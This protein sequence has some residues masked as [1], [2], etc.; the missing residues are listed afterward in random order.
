MMKQNSFIPDHSLEALEEAYQAALLNLAFQQIEQE[1][2]AMMR[3]RIHDT[4]RSPQKIQFEKKLENKIRKERAKSFLLYKLPRIAQVAACLIAVLS[5]GAGV[6]LAASREVRSWAAGVLTGTVI[7]ESGF[8]FGNEPLTLSITDGVNMDEQL[9]LVEDGETLI[10]HESM[11]AEPARYEW[12]DRGARRLSKLVAYSD[13]IYVLFEDGYKHEAAPEEEGTFTRVWL[14]ESFDRVGL[15]RVQFDADGT[16]TV[17]ALA[18][19]DGK[20]L[21]GPGVKGCAVSTAAAG[22]G[23]LYFVTVYDEP[24]TEGISFGNRR[25]RLLAYDL[26]S[27]ELTELSLPIENKDSPEC[28]LFSDGDVF[29]AASTQ[30]LPVQIWRIDTD[31]SCTRVAGFSDGNRPNSFAYRAMTD[32]LY[33]QKDSAI[34]AAAHFDV[35]NAQRV[36]L[37]NGY[38]G[39]GL[40]VGK[41]SYALIDNK[42]EVFNLDE[43]ISNVSEL[44]VGGGFGTFMNDE[45][46]EQNPELTLTNDPVENAV[47]KSGTSDIGK[48]YREKLLSGEAKA[49]LISSFYDD[50]SILYAAGWGK[51]IKDDAICAEI[52]SMPESVRRYVTRNGEY[53]AYPYNVFYAHPDLWIDSERWAELGLGEEPQTWLELMQKLSELSHSENAG[54][55]VISTNGMSL[56]Q[57]LVLNMTD[58]FARSW[59]ARGME[60]DFGGADFQ[61]AM[62]A[63]KGIDF[64]ALRCF[65]E[66]DNV[67]DNFVILSS[68]MYDP[69]AMSTKVNGITLKIH[70]EDKK[71][72]GGGCHIARINPASDAEELAYSYLYVQEGLDEPS[73]F[74]RLR[75]DFTTPA[76]ELA[77]L[78]GELAAAEEIDA[79]RAAAGDVWIGGLNMTSMEKR[80]AALDAYAKGK[81][82][83]SALAEQ[84]N[85]AY[86]DL[87]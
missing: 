66:G 53:I 12:R 82:S 75:Y 63:L 57:T 34:Y 52:D 47:Q 73:I 2:L 54:K 26:T 87:W 15:G 44:M 38:G 19:F 58:G 78:S 27:F 70:P 18:Y 24:G 31:G 46:R 41:N 5:I 10:L 21:F 39:K 55:Y 22:N 9:L 59:A 36:A 16:F 3:K 64:N 11:E 25:A 79:Y 85:S 32:T 40:L 74:E 68:G 13:T 43:T 33:F 35:A 7:D 8:G 20:D 65:E 80:N 61:T 81:T 72:S 29:L 51:P 17:E 14:G 84:L 28:E 23:K 86:T 76:E 37:S 50:D 4:S 83:F 56:A 48:L 30:E 77:E 1:E 71:I 62:E 6:A 49:D 60:M 42:V 45:L 67:E 69:V